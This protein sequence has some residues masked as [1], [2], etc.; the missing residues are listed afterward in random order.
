MPGIVELM[1]GM[2]GRGAS[3]LHL[4]VDHHPVLRV[5]GLLMPQLDWPVVDESSMEDVLGRL[6]DEQQRKAFAR[7]LELDFSFELPEGARF[8]VNLAREHGSAYATLRAIR[9]EVPTLA[10]LGLPE[11]CAQLAALTRGL[12]LVTGPTGCGKSTTLAAMIETVNQSAARRIITIEDPI[13]YVFRDQRSVITQREVGEDTHSFAAA[14]KYA[15]R[16]DPDVIMVGEM[17]DLETIAATLTAAETG[18]LVLATLHTRSAPEAVDRVVDAFPAHQQTQVRTQLAMTL[19]GVIAQRLVRRVDLGGRVPACEIMTGT[20]AIRNLI[21][22]SKTPQMVSAIQTGREHG[23]Q[24]LDQALREL[25]LGQRISL[26]EALTHAS[27]PDGFRRLV[28]T[29]VF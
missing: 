8:R 29:G 22:E 19:A 4:R 1:Q 9:Q 14:L 25:L 2:F 13:E 12:V 6:M 21:R 17:R 27:D 3:D 10:E 11:V 26:D 24:T 20:P 18:H 15:L 16:Q 28:G 7:D 5:H 23:M